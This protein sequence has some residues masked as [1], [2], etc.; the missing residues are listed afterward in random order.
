MTDKWN[1][2]IREQFQ[3]PKPNE[4]QTDRVCQKINWK[5]VSGIGVFNLRSHSRSLRA[6]PGEDHDNLGKESHEAVADVKFWL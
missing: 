3:T 2:W 4:E 5:P 1:K 6:E